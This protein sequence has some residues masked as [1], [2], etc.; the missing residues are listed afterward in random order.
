[1]A[2]GRPLENEALGS[3]ESR[4]QNR[5]KVMGPADRAL[6]VHHLTGL[7]PYLEPAGQGLQQ[8]NATHAIVYPYR[9][10]IKQ[11]SDMHLRS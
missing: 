8:R 3:A 10:N 6:K 11:G 9:G 5:A 1:V 4:L 2:M 7:G